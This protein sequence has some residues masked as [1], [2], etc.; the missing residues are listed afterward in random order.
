M[1]GV[2]AAFG[3]FFFLLAIGTP[4]FVGIFLG[5]GIGLWVVRSYDTLWAYYRF[6]LHDILAHYHFAVFPMFILIGSLAESGG[7]GLRAY[8]AFHKLLGHIRGGVLVATTYAAAAFG[9]CSGSSVASAALFSKVALP[10]LK[11]YN[12]SQEMSLGCIATAG[13]LALLIPPSGMMVIYAILT[14]TSVGR[15]LIGG[16]IPGIILASML[17]LLIYLR[18][19]INP[20]LAPQLLEPAPV[21]ERV[22]A[23]LGI[24]P[25]GLA[26]L[27]IIGSIYTGFVTP[28]EAAALGATVVLIWNFIARIRFKK[29]INAFRETAIISAQITILLVGGIMLAKVVSISGIPG[30]II[31]WIGAANLPTPVVW[32]TLILIWIILGMIIDSTS[33][34]VLTLPFAFP[35]MTG[36]GVDPITLGI[37]AILTIEMG[38]ITPPVGFNCYVVASIAGVDP[39]VAFR[40][41]MPFFLVLLLAV[42]IFIAFPILS[43]WLPTMAFG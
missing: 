8:T 39:E 33:Q 24:W 3:I 5:A 19:R 25:V 6:G 36:L 15:L 17:A 26:F 37:A 27:L 40:G 12:Y 16:I 38:V 23:M 1:L 10:E 35:V 7:L 22:T 28:S 2:G 30:V 9:A 31:S 41:I 13:G 11:K 18:V 4:V 20:K 14:E 32:L 43:T 29:I 34:L 21:L 42:V